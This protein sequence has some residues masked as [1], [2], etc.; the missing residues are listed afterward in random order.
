MEKNF[1][2][3]RIVSRDL[4]NDYEKNGELIV[5]QVTIDNFA[6]SFGAS[7]DEFSPECLKAIEDS[8]FTYRQFNRAERDAVILEVLNK[9]KNDRQV[10]AAPERKDIWEKGWAENL[11]AFKENGFDPRALVP[12]FLRENQPIRFE[13]DYIL[14]A[15]SRFEYD[16]M[17]V[18][19]LWLFQKYFSR[20]E[21]IYE[22][23]CGTGLNLVL[24]ANLWPDHSYHGLDF[25]QSAVDLVNSIGDHGDWDIQGYLF[26]MIT[27]D[28]TFELKAD[29]GILTFGAL[30]QLASQYESFI[31]YLLEQKPGMVIHVEPTIELYDKNNLFD[32]LAMEFHRKRGYSEKLLPC[33]KDLEAQGKI[34]ILKVKRLYF[35]SLF[36]EGYSYIVWKPK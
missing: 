17:T 18:F 35:G 26:D 16:Y 29:C 12:K 34:D 15:N 13:G 21:N 36:M 20:I 1:T 23:G 4:S 3:M 28:R 24:L 5:Q 27:P 25:V 22:F 19:R 7:R 30:E 10:I 31:Q 33:L 2:A 9:I 32:Y 6:A 14:P 8:D 11:A